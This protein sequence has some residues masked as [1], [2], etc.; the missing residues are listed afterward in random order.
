MRGRRG[1]ELGSQRDDV[2]ALDQRVIAVA[3]EEL[4]PERVQQDQDHPFARVDAP[5]D[6]SRDF[7]EALHYEHSRRF[8][9]VALYSPEADM[10]RTGTTHQ[11]AAALWDVTAVCHPLSA[12]TTLGF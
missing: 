7:G 8:K 6:L 3:L 10:I 5:P 9:A 12:L 1:R 11:V 2:Q 4:Q